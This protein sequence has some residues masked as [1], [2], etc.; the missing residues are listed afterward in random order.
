MHFPY[1]HFK[2][3]V[4]LEQPFLIFISYS[5]T[6]S[7]RVCYFLIHYSKFFPHCGQNLLPGA[8]VAPQSGQVLTTL[9]PQFAQNFAPLVNG[10]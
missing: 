5:A 9:V 4:P 6:L 3:A 8:T 1:F 2:K 10:A 7:G